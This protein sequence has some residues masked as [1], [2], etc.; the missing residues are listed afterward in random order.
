[1]TNLLDQTRRWGQIFAILLLLASAAL[2]VGATIEQSAGSSE[3]TSRATTGDADQEQGHVEEAEQ[4]GEPAKGDSEELLGIDPEGTPLVI[5][6]V[7]LAVLLAA[8]AWRR[9]KRPQL[10]L[11]LLYCLGAAALD[12]R[13]AL[14]QLDENNAG[15]AAI[16]VLVTLLHLLAGAAA[17]LALRRL[18][19][20]TAG[21]SAG[22]AAG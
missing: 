10:L 8:A 20:D 14:H 6:A 17:G 21:A 4:A 19:D 2:A 22:T 9:P 3:A 11:G 13:E 5:T 7:L 18:L 16:A 15:I 12:V 1:M